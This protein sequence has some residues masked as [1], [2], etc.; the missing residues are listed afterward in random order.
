MDKYPFVADVV[1]GIVMAFKGIKLSYVYVYR[2]RQFKTQ[3]EPYIFGG[4]NFSFVY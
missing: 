2:T 4:L 1:A 3:S